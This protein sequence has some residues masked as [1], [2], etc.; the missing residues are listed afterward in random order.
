MPAV[1]GRNE[2]AAASSSSLER[3][4]SQRRRRSPVR[5]VRQ[6][7]PARAEPSSQAAAGTGTAL[8]TLKCVV[9][10]L[11][12]SVLK[13]LPSASRPRTQCPAPASCAGALAQADSGSNARWL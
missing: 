9:P 3:E 1:P 4:R 13:L 11:L 2:P 5:P 12:I 8:T 7:R 10:S 6:A